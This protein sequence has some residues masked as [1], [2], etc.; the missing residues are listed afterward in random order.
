MNLRSKLLHHKKDIALFLSVFLVISG[1]VLSWTY[2]RY[3]YENNYFDFHIADTIGSIVCIPAATLFYYG[4]GNN[5]YSFKKLVFRALMTFTLYEF[6]T[7]IPFHGTFDP[8]D[9][10]VISALI[11]LFCYDLLSKKIK[12]IE[13]YN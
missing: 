7:I 2:R 13:N 12:K 10:M 4:L 11:T 6:L 3:I 8:Y 1:I 9:L 5:K